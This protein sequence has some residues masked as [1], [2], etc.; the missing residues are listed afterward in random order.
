LASDGGVVVVGRAGEIAILFNST[1]MF[2]GAADATGRF[3][4]PIWE[5][6]QTR[7]AKPPGGS[8]AGG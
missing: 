4:L 8:A 1:G 2:R 7:P 3:E 5:E 6:T